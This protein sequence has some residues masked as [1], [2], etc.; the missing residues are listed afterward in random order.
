M[1]VYVNDTPGDLIPG[2]GGVLSYMG[3]IGVCSPKWFSASFGKNSVD[4]GLK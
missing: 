1:F 3:L 4:F 2:G